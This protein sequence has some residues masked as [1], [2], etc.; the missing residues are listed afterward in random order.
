ML[1]GEFGFK[2]SVDFGVK[3]LHNIPEE[4][5]MACEL[6]PNALRGISGIITW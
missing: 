1:K 6:V 4:Y 3:Q 2:S 5:V